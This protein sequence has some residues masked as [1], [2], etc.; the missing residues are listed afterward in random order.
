GE[1]YVSF[2][3]LNLWAS[4]RESELRPNR[5]E[6]QNP[7]PLNLWGRGFVFYNA[8]AAGSRHCRQALFLFFEMWGFVV[9]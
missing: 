9:K 2:D 5:I 3:A 7:R 6:T 4:K 1:N 8:A